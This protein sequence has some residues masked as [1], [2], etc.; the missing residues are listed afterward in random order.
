MVAVAVGGVLVGGVLVGGVL[1]GGVLVGGVLVGGVLV[2]GVLVG[3]ASLQNGRVMSFV[4]RVTAPFRASTR[5]ITSVPVCT[6]TEVNAR[7]FPTKV[8]LV[9]R[10]AELPTWKNTLHAWAPLISMIVLFGAVIKVDPT[11]KMNT[12]LGSPCPSRVTVPVTPREDSALNTPATKVCPPMS[13][14][15]VASGVRPAASLNA[16]AR[17]AW[18]LAASASA[19]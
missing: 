16:L 11:W 3:G 7:M 8:V 17:S 18:A 9:P 4:S 19:A 14:D 13:G 12:A 10:V 1:V 5:P 6:V 15:N 2:G